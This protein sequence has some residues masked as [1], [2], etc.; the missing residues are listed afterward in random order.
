IF[1]SS[2]RRHTRSKR[3]WSSDVCSSDL[4][5]SLF[6][7]GAITVGPS[8]IVLIPL[9]ADNKY[10]LYFIGLV[11]SFIVGFI[12][13]YLFGFKEEMAQKVFGDRAEH[14]KKEVASTAMQTETTDIS[15]PLS[16]EIRPLYELNDDVF[17][18]ESVGKGIAI[19]PSEGKLYAPA[20]G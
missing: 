9:I 11:I 18:S 10:L 3:D 16:G 8:G 5:L 19:Y 4:F 1:F 14:S 7:V 20:S 13:T 12:L 6:T 15:S 17:A 2:R